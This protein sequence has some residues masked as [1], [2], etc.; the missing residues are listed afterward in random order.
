MTRKSS[1]SIPYPSHHPIEHSF[2]SD[3]WPGDAFIQYYK[4]SRK[5]IAAPILPHPN[6]PSNQNQAVIR[7][8]TILKSI[9]SLYV[10]YRRP[11]KV[12]KCE[13]I[14]RDHFRVPDWCA[15][16]VEDGLE[17]GG[18][19]RWFG[20]QFNIEAILL[21][22]EESCVDASH[23]WR[24]CTVISIVEYIEWLTS[25][26]MLAP[27]IDSSVFSQITD[28]LRDSNWSPFVLLL[29]S[30]LFDWFVVIFCCCCVWHFCVSAPKISQ[31]FESYATRILKLVHQPLKQWTH[32][33]VW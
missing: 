18:V 9:L 14:D 24:R 1:R 6:W 28:S 5:Q 11:Y 22:R 15:I 10:V 30:G 21:F 33:R 27:W 16:F 8:P 13:C 2:R 12:S 4:E 31:P 7:R 23:Q 29:S 19:F 17:F 25:C 26:T 3:D 20:I 32:E